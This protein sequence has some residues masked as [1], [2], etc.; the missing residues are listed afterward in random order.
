[1]I[2]LEKLMPRCKTK[3]TDD[4]KGPEELGRDERCF[5]CMAWEAIDQ[6]CKEAERRGIEKGLKLESS[7]HVVNEGQLNQQLNEI[8]NALKVLVEF[9]GDN[10]D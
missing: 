4:F 2:D 5:N 1:M 8:R 3:D 9:Q 7:R 10:N 6:R